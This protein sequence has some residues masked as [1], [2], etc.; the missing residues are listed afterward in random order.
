MQTNTYR[1]QYTSW[2][3]ETAKASVKSNEVMTLNVSNKAT[4]PDNISIFC[5]KMQLQINMIK[6]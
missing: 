5:Q 4:G 2:M 6:P 1:E 3:N